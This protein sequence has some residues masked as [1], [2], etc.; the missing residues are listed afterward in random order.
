LDPYFSCYRSYSRHIE[1]AW[2]DLNPRERPIHPGWSMGRG[3]IY[4]P[5]WGK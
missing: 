4:L 5:F 2:C 1:S 3:K